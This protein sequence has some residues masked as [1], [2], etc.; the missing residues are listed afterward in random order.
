MQPGM[1]LFKVFSRFDQ[2]GLPLVRIDQG[3]DVA[4]QKFVLEALFDLF[5][6]IFVDT[7]TAEGT[8]DDGRPCLR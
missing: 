2:Q 1:G 7:D 3:T 4:D 5:G 8:G 6:R